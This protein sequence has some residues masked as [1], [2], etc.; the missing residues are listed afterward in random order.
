[1]MDKQG[2]L[3][4]LLQYKAYTQASEFVPENL[5]REARRQ[6]SVPDGRVPAICVLDPDGDIVAHL[7][8]RGEA[9]QNAVWACYHTTMYNFRTDNIECGIIGAVVGAPFAAL[10][11]EELFA[12]GCELL[13][14][15]TSSGQ[16]LPT[17]QPPFFILVDKALRDEGTSYHYLPPSEFSHLNPELL[18]LF[19]GACGEIDTPV[20]RGATWTTDAPF[21]ETQ[22]AIA[23]A[24]ARGILAVEMEV[25]A[26]YAFAQARAKPV[27]CFAHI[28]NQMGHIE[29]DFEKG[30][31]AGS[32]AALQIITTAA[33]IWLTS[34]SVQSAKPGKG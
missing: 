16:I 34:Q 18:S 33:K 4:P 10:V 2:T 28:T 29:G 14:H 12:S 7:V 1:M 17:R 24:Q 13:I 19:D 22:T 8:A 20:Y 5:L 32:R 6:K 9:Q 21:R 23:H 15:V 31:D 3:P 27:V 26:L 25:A 11:A 30:E